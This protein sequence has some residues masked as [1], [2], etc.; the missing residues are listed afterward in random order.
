MELGELI[1]LYRQQAGL[2]IDDLVEK[3][4]VP[5]GTITKIIGGVTKAPTLENVKAIARALDKRLA[6]FDDDTNAEDSFSLAERNIIKKYRL[7]DPDGQ[8]HINTVLSWETARVTA[9]LELENSVKDMQSVLKK[10][11]AAMR[12]Y[13]YLHKI[14]AA[15]TGFYFEDIP[16]DTI[17]A[18]YCENADFII[19]VS[20][21]SMEPTYND[22]DLV[23]VEKCQIVHTGDVGIFI[24]NNEI[25][26][27]EAGENGL[28]SHNSKY[29]PIP[30]SENIICIGKVLK[31]V[32]AD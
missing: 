20:G 32:N 7:L 27:K 22:G 1:S 19:G 10:A 31:K 5:K 16:T 13:T 28:I 12:I 2:T 25:Y 9:L 6:D 23:Y 18:P 21:D 24:V 14:A 30:G 3:S 17:E 4:G 15:G 11:S 8:A 26:I 29:D